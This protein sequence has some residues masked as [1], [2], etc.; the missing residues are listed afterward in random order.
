MGEK[1]CTIY[2]HRK[3]W[4]NTKGKKW[5]EL[6]KVCKQGIAWPK[7]DRKRKKMKASKAEK[8]EAEMI[9]GSRTH[10]YA[11]WNPPT[12]TAHCENQHCRIHWHRCPTFWGDMGIKWNCNH[13]WK[14]PLTKFL[15]ESTWLLWQKA[16]VK[17]HICQVCFYTA[18]SNSRK[19]D[20]GGMELQSIIC[21]RMMREKY[22]TYVY[23][24]QGDG[25][26]H[27]SEYFFVIS[28]SVLLNSSWF[29][30]IE[31]D[32]TMN[33]TDGLHLREEQHFTS[34]WNTG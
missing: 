1:L 10:R 2:E 27:Y 34:R 30:L 28:C 3:L 4:C 20:S 26:W 8:Q 13:T 7:G 23:G 6:L 15:T 9:G 22:S 21:N 14:E 19:D 29:F 33:S 32:S 24:F 16:D 31:L 17:E 18:L 11:C 25:T 12:V 5:R